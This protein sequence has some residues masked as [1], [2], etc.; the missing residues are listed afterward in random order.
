[1]LL[2]DNIEGLEYLIELDKV[3]DYY[4]LIPEL[5]KTFRRRFTLRN[6]R[7]SNRCLLIVIT[8]DETYERFIN[9]EY[10]LQKEK[11][12]EKYWKRVNNKNRKKPTK[13]EEQKEEE[14]FHQLYNP[15]PLDV[16]PI[17][18]T[19]DELLLIENVKKYLGLKVKNEYWIESYHM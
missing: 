4:E 11:A 13:E 10:H 6:T 2:I 3:Y 17:T 14:E 1:M 18:I 15:P 7:N 8:I 12:K 16:L 5:E 9:C 19:Q